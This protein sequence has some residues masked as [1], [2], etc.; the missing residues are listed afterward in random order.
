MVGEDCG[1]FLAWTF[2]AL[3]PSVVS[4][5]AV[6]GMP[7]PL[8]LG[9]AL[10]TDPRGQLPASRQLFTFQ[11][12]RFPESLLLSDDAA[13]VG[14]LLRRWSGPRWTSTPDFVEAE[15]RYREAIRIRKTAHCALEYYRWI[16]RSATRPSGW[17][18]AKLLQ[19]PVTAPTL[20]LHGE[21]D[22]CVL[23]RTAQ[24]SGR[25]VA[26]SYEW[27][28]VERAGHFVPEEAPDR[29]TG[30]LVRWAKGL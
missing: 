5:F 6:I 8:R 21:L 25:Y 13:F 24:G 17:R 2:P 4:R 7:H 9:A 12:P 30:E 23:P 3:H 11:A 1:G 28:L 29:V 14:R 20:H 15:H 10:V 19:R 18:F 22:P 27:H 26:A 16:V